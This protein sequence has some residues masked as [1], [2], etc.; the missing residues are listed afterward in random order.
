MRFSGSHLTITTRAINTK[1]GVFDYVNEV[2]QKW[3]E[4]VG[5]GRLFILMKYALLS[6]FHACYKLQLALVNSPLQANDRWRCDVNKK[7]DQ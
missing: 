2:C 6:L 7:T 3:L 4:S 5:S 1:F